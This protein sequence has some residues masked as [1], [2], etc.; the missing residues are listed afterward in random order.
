MSEFDRPSGIFPQP[1]PAGTD[2]G[3]P[4]VK[5]SEPNKDSHHISLAAIIRDL[6]EMSVSEGCAW[7]TYLL[8]GRLRDAIAR[9]DAIERHPALSIPPL[10][11]PAPASVQASEIAGKLREIITGIRAHQ[12][13][14]SEAF[15]WSRVVRQLASLA[16]RLAPPATISSASE[17]RQARCIKCGQWA[18]LD[19]AHRCEDCGLGPPAPASEPHEPMTALAS[20]PS[21]PC[22]CGRKGC[23]YDSY[24]GNVSHLPEDHPARLPFCPSTDIAAAWQVVE[25]MRGE[26]R[27]FEISTAEEGNSESASVFFGQRRSDDPNGEHP[28]H[29]VADTVPMAIC[30]AALATTKGDANGK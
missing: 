28:S 14:A 23:T 7:H 29:A 11:H 18:F 27:Y 30:L 12:T 1:R 6:G 22:S 19:E 20:H 5:Q 26:G 8:A 10:A 2:R 4:S 15:S 17:A 13:G 24:H 3:G 25:K 9:L 21:W 16:D